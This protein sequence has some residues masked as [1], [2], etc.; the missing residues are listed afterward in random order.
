MKK[1]LTLLLLLPC[2]SCFAQKV[3]LALNLKKDSTYYLNSNAKLQITQNIQGQLMDIGTTITGKIAHKVLA[4]NDT[5]YS[6][7][8]TYIAIGMDMDM[9]G[10]AIKFDSDG[11]SNGNPMADM[12]GKMM[13]AMTNKPI[14]MELSKTGHIVSIKNI[15]ALFDG[16][17][18]AFPQLPEAQRAQFKAQMEKS[19]GE[20]SLKNSFQQAF[21]A[22]PAQ[23]IGVNDKWTGSSTIQSGITARINTTYTLSQITDKAYLVTGTGVIV[24]DKNAAPVTTNGMSTTFTSISGNVNTEF[25][26]DKVTGWIKSAKTTESVNAS[27]KV[28]PTTGD[29]IAYP[30]TIKVNSTVLP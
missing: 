14:Y 26:F 28:K 11:S 19:F 21:P 23:K 9:A 22:F 24:E 10:T 5:T 16:M 15:D 6:M 17:F 18:D 20:A 27:V 30:I 2:F 25:A 12:M 4:I 29:E 7:R 8:V 1:Y 3:T 13:K